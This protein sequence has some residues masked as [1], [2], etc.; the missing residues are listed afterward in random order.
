M[1]GQSPLSKPLSPSSF[2][3]DGAG[4]LRNHIATRCQ[5]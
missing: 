5:K 3:N 4:A 2:G 1:P